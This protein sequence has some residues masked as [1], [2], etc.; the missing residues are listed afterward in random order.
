MAK[1]SKTPVLVS[2]AVPAACTGGGTSA[3]IIAPKGA[4]AS[5]AENA[6]TGQKAGL[7]PTGDVRLTANIRGDLHLKL[8][9]RAAQERTT[10]GELIEQWIERW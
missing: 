5:K 3:A 9:I 1:V 10:A 7:V 4:G 2:E 8:K 6:P